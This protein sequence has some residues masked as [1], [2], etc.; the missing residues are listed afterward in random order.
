MSSLQVTVREMEEPKFIKAEIE[1]RFPEKWAKIYQILNQD[2]VMPNGIRI[3][4]N[5]TEAINELKETVKTWEK[6][7][8]KDQVSFADVF[9]LSLFDDGNPDK[10]APS[11]FKNSIFGK[12]LWTV[13]SALTTRDPELDKYKNDFRDADP[14]EI[15]DVVENI[16]TAAADYAEELPEF[17]KVREPSE[18]ELEILEE[19]EY[20]LYGVIGRGIRS[21]LLHRLYPQA[22][23]LMTQ[24]NLWGMFFLTNA[25]E[26][27]VDQ[28]DESTGKTRTSHYWEYDYQVFSFY[29]NFLANLLSHEFK[30]NGLAFSENMRFGYVNNFLVKLYESHKKEVNEMKRWKSV[31]VR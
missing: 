6:T 24:R 10:Y 13:S 19:E 29:C 27:L 25:D 5:N 8:Q 2:I 12:E 1:K 21:E 28:F 20:K 11:E 22:F 7:I 16:L 9:S 26:F 31:G 30:K 15:Y 14:R 4:K 3:K 18:M 17:K 23:A